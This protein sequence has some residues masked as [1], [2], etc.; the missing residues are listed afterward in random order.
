M[1]EDPMVERFMDVN[2]SDEEL[3]ELRAWLE[4]HMCPSCS[5][6]NISVDFESVLDDEGYLVGESVDCHCFNVDCQRSE[7]IERNLD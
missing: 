1:F 3:D 5:S 7:L 4:Y 6:K 2:C